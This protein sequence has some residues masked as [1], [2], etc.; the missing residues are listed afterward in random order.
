MSGISAASAIEFR[1]TASCRQAPIARN[2][3]SRIN[4]TKEAKRI[5][6][7][8]LALLRRLQNVRASPAIQMSRHAV[9]RPSSVRQQ[10]QQRPKS[11]RPKV[12]FTL[13]PKGKVFPLTGR[14]WLVSQSK[15]HITQISVQIVNTWTDG[16]WNKLKEKLL[17]FCVYCLKNNKIF[18]FS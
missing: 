16:W 15:Q 12:S 9:M 17:L 7:E 1:K 11:V 18:I 8:N 14:R 2:Y 3:H 6:E 5:D 4:R 10:Q 13:G